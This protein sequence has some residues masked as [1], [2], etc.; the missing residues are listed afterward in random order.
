M[1]YKLRD[2]DNEIMQ[3]S[4]SLYLSPDSILIKSRKWLYLS[5]SHIESISLEKN[6]MKI[7]LRGYLSLEFT[8]RNNYILNALYHYIEGI[9]W[10]QA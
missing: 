1:N 6:K 8:I 2:M 9:K 10:I 7:S 5:S 4:G 3:G